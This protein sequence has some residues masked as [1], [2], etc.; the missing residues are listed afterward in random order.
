MK[1]QTIYLFFGI[2]TLL[3]LPCKADTSKP[4]SVKHW[5]IKNSIISNSEQTTLSNWSAGG[6]NSF[7]FSN[8]YKGFFNYKNGKNQWDNSVELAYG[9]IWQDKTGNGYKDKSNEFQKS[10]D[11]IEINSIFSRK[12]Y[13]SWNY[14]ALVNLK[15]QFDEGFKDEALISA[16]LSPII[17]TSS[18]GWE[19]KR[20][21]F[22]TLISFL[23]GK[24][25]IVEDNRL[26]GNN[27]FGFT[28]PDQTTLFSLG[29]YIKFYFQKDIFKNINL[30]AK[31][32]FFYD[33]NKPS[34]LDTDIST[35]IFLNMKISKYLTAFIS[36][37]AIMDKDFN[38]TLQYKERMG[39]SIPINF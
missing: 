5:D 6:F 36:F 37:Q 18:I 3:C 32:D 35:E 39:F 9:M 11:K 10:D 8:F 30:L 13:K 28:E 14:S 23:T 20:S 27:I 25:T 2:L 4:D 7:A 29:S 34:I 21:G 15:S 38:T 1:K 22:S 33:Y 17:I 26:K 31:L 12:M 16:P 24:T 19:Y